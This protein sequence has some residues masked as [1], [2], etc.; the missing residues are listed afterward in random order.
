M[1]ACKKVSKFNHRDTETARSA[2]RNFHALR[3]NRCLCVSVVICFL[4]P[5]S[6]PPSGDQ[7][8]SE[9]SVGVGM[10]RS[11]KPVMSTEAR[12]EEKPSPRLPVAR[13]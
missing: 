13:D 10:V 6:Y 3:A 11:L 4:S 2:Q 1:H 8:G 12:R 5:D 9:A 7:A